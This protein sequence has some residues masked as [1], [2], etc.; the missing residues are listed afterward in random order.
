MSPK[1]VSLQMWKS[2]DWSQQTLVMCIWSQGGLNLNLG[3]RC[4]CQVHERCLQYAYMY[5]NMWSLIGDTVWE[6]LG[7]TS[8]Q[9]KYATDSLT[10]FP[11]CLCFLVWSLSFPLLCAIMSTVGCHAFPPWW[12]HTSG[13]TSQNKFFLLSRICFWSWCFMTTVGK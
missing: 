5:L 1:Y 4:C 9:M 8:L 3:C 13:T 6:G 10:A 7:G 11:V 2:N 12:N